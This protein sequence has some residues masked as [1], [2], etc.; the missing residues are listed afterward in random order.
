M[1]LCI[2]KI[3][4]PVVLLCVAA[5]GKVGCSDDFVPLDPTDGVTDPY[6]IDTPTW[7]EELTITAAYSK[8]EPD[9]VVVSFEPNNQI[10]DMNG[11]AEVDGAEVDSFVFDDMHTIWLVLAPHD[12]VD[13]IVIHSAVD[14]T[15]ETKRFDLT[16]HLFPEEAEV[17]YDLQYIDENAAD[18][19]NEDDAGV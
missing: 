4:T 18:A 16:L 6:C 10:V 7:Y 9:L 19:G 8:T 2:A 11:L 14:C 1:R 12:G 3:I 5:A 15:T 13:T 17:T